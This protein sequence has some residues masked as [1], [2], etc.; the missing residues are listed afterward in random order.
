MENVTPFLLYHHAAVQHRI[1]VMMQGLLTVQIQIPLQGL[2][3][4]EKREKVKGASGYLCTMTRNYAALQG[5]MGNSF[6]H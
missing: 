1:T 3:I 2:I 6:G 4:Q 5:V